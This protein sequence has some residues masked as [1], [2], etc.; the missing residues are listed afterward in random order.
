MMYE[1]E[2]AFQQH[3][4]RNGA[5]AAESTAHKE[6]ESASV[7]GSE[8]KQP[9]DNGSPTAGS[10]APLTSPVPGTSSLVPYESDADSDVENEAT[11]NIQRDRKVATTPDSKKRA[12]SSPICSAATSTTSWRVSTVLSNSR[13]E[14]GKLG[15]SNSSN[16]GHQF[17]CYKKFI[18]LACVTKNKNTF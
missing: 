3:N 2:R 10:P 1:L 17:Y 12:P 14:E 11:E 18:F 15:L 5:A 16:V 13:Y 9:M 4:A 7:G 6:S 8:A